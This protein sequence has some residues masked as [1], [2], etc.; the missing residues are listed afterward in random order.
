[1]T[2]L[3]LLLWISLGLLAQVGVA[4]AVALLRTKRQPRPATP[5]AAQT[6][7]TPLHPAAWTG[8]RAFRVARR[9]YEDAAHTQCSFYLEPVDGV[10][11]PAFKP[12]QFLTFSLAIPAPAG[13]TGVAITRCYSLSDSP[14]S[15]HYRITIKRALAPLCTP[16]V[17]AGVAS[18][19]F[20]DHV[21]V[22]SVL[23]V[24]APAGSFFVDTDASTPVVLIGGGIGITPMMSM[25]R[26]CLAQQPGRSIHLYY[27]VRNSS[28]HAFQRTLK[29]LAAQSPQLHL[30]MVYSKPNPTDQLGADYQHTGH[31]DVTLLQRTLLHGRH[32]FYVCGPSTMMESLVPALSQWGVAREDIHFEAFGP[33]TVRLVGADPVA[34][35][36]NTTASL[37]VRFQRSGRTLVWAGRESNLLDFAE[38]HGISIESGCRSGSCGSCLTTVVSGEVQYETTP[39]FE[40]AAGQCLLCVAKPRSALV[41][42]A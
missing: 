5:V 24:R 29:D 12:G 18:N 41:L 37:E 4:I 36:A 28:E 16:A 10:D 40:L 33:A 9:D 42:Q 26:W 7:T 19:Y 25:L 2:A 1:V 22:G 17:P 23:Q 35:A 11:L 31:I 27:G 14:D 30:N 32:A 6:T 34:E 13:G 38:R 15:Q 8:L 21:H 39:N 3:L 20:H